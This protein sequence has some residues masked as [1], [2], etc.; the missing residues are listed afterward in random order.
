MSLADRLG[1]TRA[2]GVFVIFTCDKCGHEQYHW[3]PIDGCLH[4]RACAQC[5]HPRELK[6]MLPESF[7]S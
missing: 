2:V 1:I 6:P 3:V 7:R 5:A 4:I